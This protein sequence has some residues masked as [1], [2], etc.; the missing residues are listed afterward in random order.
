MSGLRRAPRSSRATAAIVSSPWI[1]VAAGVVVMIVL[2]VIALGAYRSRSGADTAPAPPAPPLLLPEAP[3][4]SSSAAPSPT[5][6]VQPGLSPR[7]SVQPTTGVARPPH[8]TPG[9]TSRAAHPTSPPPPAG[10]TGR[11]RVVNSF[12]GG[13]I[14]EILVRNGSAERRGWTVRLTYAGGRFVTAW[15]EG[16]EQGKAT[17]TEGGFT[18]RSGVDV[19]PGGSATLRFHMERTESRPT[20]CTVDGVPCVLG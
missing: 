17:P 7:T 1:L 4:P 11:Y 16:T 15:V 13:F 8:P 9:V 20:G 6:A 14:G 18:Y 5:G 3:P 12:D 19:A 2:L 10:T